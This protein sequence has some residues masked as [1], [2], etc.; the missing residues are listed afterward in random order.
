MSDAREVHSVVIDGKSVPAL[1]LV[2]HECDPPALWL[3]SD[4]DVE[5]PLL[6]VATCPHGHSWTFAPLTGIETG[7]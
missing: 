3:D 2:C 6:W 4:I 7:N 5:N 1:K